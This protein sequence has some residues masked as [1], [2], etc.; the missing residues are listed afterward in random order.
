VEGWESTAAQIQE[1]ILKSPLIVTLFRIYSRALTFE[2]VTL[3]IPLQLRLSFSLLGCATSTPSILRRSVPKRM[4][5][6]RSLLPCSRVVGLF[7]LGSGL[8]LTRVHVA[9]CGSAR[10]AES[11]QPSFSLP[12]RRESAAREALKSRHTLSKVQCTVILCRIHKRALTFEMLAAAVTR[13]CPH[14]ASLSQLEKVRRLKST[15]GNEY[16]EYKA[17][18]Q[19]R[20]KKRAE[21]SL[22]R[23]FSNPELDPFLAA[24]KA[25]LGETVYNRYV[26]RI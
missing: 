18:E 7:C 8:F 11:L 1:H 3:D 6:I 21:T 20:E 4:P 23:T 24:R 5:C 16:D 19:E 17:V 14:P 13:S 12:T 25:M 2:N 22:K 26:H 15:E 10:E 9:G